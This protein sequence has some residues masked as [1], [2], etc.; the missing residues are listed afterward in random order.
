ML[1]CLSLFL[2]DSGVFDGLVYKASSL[3][4]FDAM[5]CFQIADGARV[6]DPQQLGPS[7]CFRIILK[8]YDI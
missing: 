6:C 1:P 8:R 4:L 3:I 7:E 2:F 5:A